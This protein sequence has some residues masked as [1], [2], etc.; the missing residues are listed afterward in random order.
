MRISGSSCCFIHV[1]QEAEYPRDRLIGQVRSWVNLRI[2][3]LW[4]EGGALARALCSMTRA[5]KAPDSLG[6]QGLRGKGKEPQI[7]LWFC[8]QEKREGPLDSL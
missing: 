7:L 8:D 3:V 5:G 1:Q 4:P 6:A 2:A